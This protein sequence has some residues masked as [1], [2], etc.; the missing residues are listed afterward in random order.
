MSSSKRRTGPLGLLAKRAAEGERGVG[1]RPAGG[2][3]ASTPA[4]NRAEKDLAVPFGTMVGELAALN[5]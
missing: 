5:R 4:S 3:L 1:G 2:H